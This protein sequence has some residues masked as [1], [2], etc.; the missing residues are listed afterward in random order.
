M[1]KVLITFVR[2]IAIAV[3]IVSVGYLIYY[4]SGDIS[5]FRTN[6]DIEELKQEGLHSKETENIPEETNA[7][8]VL[9]SYKSLYEENNDVIG[10]L[11]INGTGIDYVVMYAPEEHEKYLHADFYGNYSSRGC[12]YLSEAC[13]PL[14]SDNLIIYGHHM[15]DGSMFGSLIDYQSESFYREHK[16]IKFDTIYEQHGYEVVAAIKT[17]IPPADEECFRYYAYTDENDPEMFAQY[18]EFIEKN[19]LYDTGIEL[20]EGDKLLTLSTCAYH[21]DNGRFIVVA[22]QLY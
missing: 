15:K 18:K 1:K 6:R 5:D 10:W 7:P 9:K 4:I 8:V 20:Q 14:H 12:L 16:N 3:L 19:A 11:R 13:D 17:S 21:T 22:R 2:T